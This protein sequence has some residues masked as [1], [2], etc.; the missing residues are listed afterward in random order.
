MIHREFDSIGFDLSNPPKLIVKI[1]KI[2]IE[3]ILLIWTN[4]FW[5][6]IIQFDLSENNWI[7]LHI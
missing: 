1:S 5:N 2:Y 7:R 4:T 6:S 3:N